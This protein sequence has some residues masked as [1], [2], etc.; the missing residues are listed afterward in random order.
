MEII[1]TG[2]VIRVS[3]NIHTHHTNN[4]QQNITK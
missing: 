4:K 2:D 3:Y 1:L